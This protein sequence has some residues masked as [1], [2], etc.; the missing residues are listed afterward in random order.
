VFIHD[1]DAI[2]YT[3]AVDIAA[4][5]VL[6]LGELVAVA[7]RPIPAG[8]PGSLSVT[9]VFDFPKASGE[10]TAIPA[11]VDVY[12]DAASKHAT[13][14]A[15]GG[16]NKRIGRSIAAAGDNAPTMRVRLSQ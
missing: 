3:P 6:V 5:D 13:T 4:G 11:G 12:W 8:T 7:K 2:D 15:G 14:D 16:T 1:G 10:G 9:G